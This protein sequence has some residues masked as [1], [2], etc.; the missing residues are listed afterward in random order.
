VC[1][2]SLGGLGLTKDQMFEADA[3]KGGVEVATARLIDEHAG[4]AIVL[5]IVREPRAIRD[6]ASRRPGDPCE[7][8]QHVLD[9]EVA[10][11]PR[12]EGSRSSR[13]IVRG[14]R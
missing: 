6:N 3:L 1:E 8:R 2:V 13:A 5:V 11:D 7:R 14:A 9:A 10:L 12:L 4:D